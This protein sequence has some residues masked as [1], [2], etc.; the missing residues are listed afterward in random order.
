M[1]DVN[2]I[3]SALKIAN[4]SEE[5]DD[6]VMKLIDYCNYYCGQCAIDPPSNEACRALWSTL[7]HR[8]TLKRFYKA[9]DEARMRIRI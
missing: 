7:G 5:L 6:A 3:E 1:D 9:L 4:T 8:E 2:E